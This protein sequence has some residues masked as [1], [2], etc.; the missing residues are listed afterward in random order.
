MKNK[1]TIKCGYGNAGL[2]IKDITVEKQIRCHTCNEL[3]K[4]TG[5]MRT[6]KCK[7][8]E[9]VTMMDGVLLRKNVHGRWAP[10]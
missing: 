1:L 4:I 6:A 8:G 7:C 3:L 2:E 10:F 9:E 5:D